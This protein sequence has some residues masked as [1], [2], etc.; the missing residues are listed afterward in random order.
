MRQDVFWRAWLGFLFSTTSRDRSDMYET[1]LGFDIGFT[2]RLQ[3]KIQKF[4]DGQDLY[5]A[6][7]RLP[8]H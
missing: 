5:Y 6:D 1:K 3:V 4:K 7:L 2:Q 8:V